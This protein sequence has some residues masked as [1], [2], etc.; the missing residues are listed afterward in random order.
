MYLYH[1]PI[2]PARNM[3]R[4]SSHRARNLPRID[5][6]GRM[7]AGATAWR[8]YRNTMER[9]RIAEDYMIAIDMPIVVRLAAIVGGAA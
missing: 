4:A 3:L 2:P 8:G 6:W 7:F 1:R 9:A 5:W